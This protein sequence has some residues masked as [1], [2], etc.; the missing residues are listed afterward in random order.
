M[1]LHTYTHTHTHAH[2]QEAGKAN[3]V[4][5]SEKKVIWLRCDFYLTLATLNSFMSPL[6]TK[7]SP[8]Q[9]ISRLI[10]YCDAHMCDAHMCG[11]CVCPDSA[12]FS[13]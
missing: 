12:C 13:L 7:K 1:G 4:I 10:T 2:A 6:N 9:H 5:K 3:L 8:K 11:V